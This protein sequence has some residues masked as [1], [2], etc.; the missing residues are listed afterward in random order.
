M[1][2]GMN[3]LKPIKDATTSFSRSVLGTLLFAFGLFLCSSFS[4]QAHIDNDVSRQFEAL[5]EAAPSADV[6]KV[7][8]PGPQLQRFDAV[9]EDSA[10]VEAS[11]GWRQL[12]AALARS[13]RN[14]FASISETLNG[15]ISQ[16]TART[17]KSV[18][19]KPLPHSS[20]YA[21]ALASAP[22]LPQIS[23]TPVALPIGTPLC[24]L[25]AERGLVSYPTP[26][27]YG[28]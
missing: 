19:D 23:V 6:F 18:T 4:A 7:S 22:V 28:C 5:L 1:G 8:I 17:P 13:E 27:P 15:N 2:K 24:F 9:D 16:T 3:T 26:P 21:A 25:P 11:S 14:L 12:D 10:L 20:G